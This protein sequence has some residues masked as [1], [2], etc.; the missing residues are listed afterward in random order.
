VDAALNGFER[1]VHCLLGLPFDAVDLAGAARRVREAVV[2]RRPYAMATPNLDYAVACRADPE[3]RD[4]V[5]ASD[6]SLADGMPLVWVARIVGAPIP[7]RVA[8]S[9]LFER[10]RHESAPRLLVYF[11]GGKD[12]VAEAACR[13]LGADEDGLACAGF[14]SPGFGTLEELSRP[15]RLARINASE[16]DLL[17][18][19]VSARKG[20][21]WIERNRSRLAVP[22]LSN[23]GATVN[24]AAGTV[25]RAPAWMRAAGLEWLWRMKE[26]PALWRRYLGNGLEFLRLLATRVLPLA[27]ALRRGRPTPQALRDAAIEWRDKA[28]ETV[29]RLRGPWAGENLARLRAVFARAAQAP[30]ALCLDLGEA[31]YGDTGFLGLLVLLY[32]A[33]RRARLPFVCAPVG[34]AMRRVFEYGCVEFLLADERAAVVQTGAL[35]GSGGGE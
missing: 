26:E 28:G 32:G 17:V 25:A 10:L 6:L 35:A 16:A 11:F 20:Q 13:R 2:A 15:E 27:L 12:G 18:V 5:I 21:F 4:A 7:D 19:S 14:D 22:V 30:G 24:F 31:T 9:D 8:G 1:D 33:R 23:L 3:F 29:I 34:G